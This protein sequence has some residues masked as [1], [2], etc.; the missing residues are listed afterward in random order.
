MP[1]KPLQTIF[2]RLFLP[3]A[4]FVLGGAFLYGQAE[5][6]GELSRLKALETLNVGLGAGA[7]SRN[8]DATIRDLKFLASHTALVAA[9]DAPTQK[10]LQHLAEDFDTFS[11]SNGTYTQLRWIDETGMEA[12]RVDYTKGKAVVISTDK[13]QNKGKRYFFT[14]AFKLKPGEV[15]VSPL[16][17]NVEQDKI[18]VPYMPMLRV[19]TP[20][21]N[22]Q[23]VKRGIVILNFN[24]QV[25]LDSFTAATPTMADHA[26]VLNN[27][28]YWLK[29]PKAADEWGFMFKR[30]D[31]SLAARAPS[32]WAEIRSM[33]SGQKILADGLWT[34]Q[35]VYPLDVGVKSSAGAD[36]AF[37]PSR[38]EVDRNQY[39]WKSVA[40]VPADVLSATRQA[41]FLK[42]A[43]AS[44]LLLGLL[45]LGSW[46]L[47]IAWVK[48]AEAEEAVRRL[49]AGLEQQV[50]SRTREL[51]LKVSEL[52]EEIAERKIADANA[53]R[54]RVRLQTILKTASDGIHILDSEGVLVEASEAFLKM[55]GYD[56]SLIG[57][58]WITDWDTPG[59]GEAIKAR[60][61]DL[62]ERRAQAIF[63]SRH[64]R[65]DGS[66]VEVE[67]NAVGI[68]IDGKGYLYA[69]SRDI[70]ERKRAEDALSKSERSLREAQEAGRVGSYLFDIQR[71]V[72]SSSAVMDEIFGIG[73]DYPRT[74]A[75]WIQILHPVERAAMNSYFGEII[76]E[77]R[78]FDKE[79]RIVRVNDG[80]ERWVLG[81]GK[82]EYDAKD[83]ASRMTGII[84]DITE[85]RKTEADLN[86]HRYHL[87]EEVLARTTELAAAKEAAE[88]ANVAKSAF[89]ANMSHEIRTPMNGILGMA[90]ILR[91]EGVSPQQARRLDVIDTSA[92]HLLSVINDI[93]DI[94]KIEAGKFALEEAPVV[95]NNLLKNVVSIVSERCK[96]RDIRLL[97]QVEPLPPNLVGDPTRLQQALLNYATNAVRFTD[98]GT[99]TLR[100]IK[101]EETAESVR[102]RFEVQD[103]GIGIT[104]EAMSRLFSAFEQADNSMTRKYGGTG[105]GL[106]ITRRL[107]ELMGGEAGAESTPRVGST[108]WFTARL[109]RGGEMLVTEPIGDAETELRQRY[110]GSRILV[111]DD[112]PI[113]LEIARLQLEAVDLVVDTAPD[114]AAAVALARTNNYAAIFMDMQMPKLNGVEA[115]Q[116]IRQ[117]PGHRDTPIIAMT[118][119]AFAED[120]E[121]CLRAG[122]NDFLTKPY[123]PTQLYAILLRSLSRSET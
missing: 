89:L 54:E 40:H 120:K 118:A 58:K 50:D 52:D 30:A 67:I 23:G 55:V 8:L 26:M 47:A 103:T 100:T 78:P 32:C 6:E 66:I 65:R 122:M 64:R 117:L 43:V 12:V 27:E 106:A 46:R 45:G 16:D 15:F 111:A 24:G 9:V 75:S 33:D 2:L 36:E 77:H 94:S 96:A 109:K 1:H 76:Q 63:E 37:A 59:S 97:V 28:G 79:Y 92:H 93:L 25:M 20:V 62:I 53:E 102:V 74:L 41:V 104:P 31:L 83:V 61:A 11:R 91:R 22:S 69:A 98:K 72:W 57:K 110:S 21:T 42:L 3:L 107:A 17:L 81:R 39:F 4:V 84:Q 87:E 68:V 73:P 116:Q 85:R 108:F 95:V 82:I 115:S 101:Q 44:G 99:V 10:N 70:T 13:L 119:N 105:L 88:A 114:G 14:D 18:E 121:R 5:I 48:R 29:S 7:L 56:D 35:T 34:W 123:N 113:N 90:S 86:Q 51:R 49:N 80:A 71:D 38:G 60:H 112:E 19:A